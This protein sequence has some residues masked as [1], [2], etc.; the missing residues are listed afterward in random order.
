MLSFVR[1]FTSHIA[2]F[3]TPFPSCPLRSTPVQG[4]TASRQGDQ[5]PSASAR[6]RDIATSRS[7]NSHSVFPSPRDRYLSFFFSFLGYPSLCLPSL[8]P[9]CSLPSTSSIRLPR[10]EKNNNKNQKQSRGVTTHDPLF[11]ESS[12]FFLSRSFFQF[13]LP[14]P[15]PLSLLTSY[16]L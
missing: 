16:K 5:E 4:A 7:H 8:S 10:F 13:F 11:L 14:P 2:H 15:P 3:G 9:L 12:F 1:I 6:T